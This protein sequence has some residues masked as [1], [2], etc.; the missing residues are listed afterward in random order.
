MTHANLFA[1]LIASPCLTHGPT[2]P[3]EC[4]ARTR[5]QWND[6]FVKISL[7]PSH[8][9]GMMTLL[10]HARFCG[11]RAQTRPKSTRSSNETVGKG[12]CAF[13]T[14]T[15]LPPSPTPLRG[16]DLHSVGAIERDHEQ[17][18]LASWAA[19]AAAIVAAS[20][21]IFAWARQC[22]VTRT[23]ARYT[24]THTG[25]M[26]PFLFILT[27]ELMQASQSGHQD[28]VCVAAAVASSQAGPGSAQ[29]ELGKGFPGRGPR[30]LCW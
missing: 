3:A 19:S 14:G 26:L 27:P 30:I 10:L 4:D 17:S 12:V 29:G 1:A 25:R 16:P 2:S 22:G 8:R 28:R 13:R 5:E 9:C 18:C 24:C 21:A 20:A 11:F 15:C 6:V 7:A 23:L